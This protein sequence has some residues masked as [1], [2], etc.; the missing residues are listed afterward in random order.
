MLQNRLHVCRCPYY[1]SLISINNNNNFACAH[2]F[3]HFFAAVLH[4][5]IVKRPSYAFYGG[6]V[7]WV[8]VRFFFTA[9]YFH[10]G[11]R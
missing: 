8:R 11:G 6:T 10:L 5:H 3:A 1:C 2:F 7:V 9:A 4:Y